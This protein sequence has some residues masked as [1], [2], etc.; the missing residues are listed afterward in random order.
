MN[1]QQGAAGG[2]AA[3]GAPYGGLGVYGPGSTA[4]AVPGYGVGT[5]GLGQ[6]WGVAAPAAGM[7]MAVA[8]LGVGGIGMG[9]PADGSVGLAGGVMGQEREVLLPQA[10]VPGASL[11]PGVVAGGQLWAAG[12]GGLQ[13]RPVSG[14]ASGMHAGEQLQQGQPSQAGAREEQGGDK[15]KKE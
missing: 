14:L 5:A 2:T 13:H 11:V 9:M 6:G 12:A 10:V 8:P 7:G 1:R 3:A 15:R 4:G